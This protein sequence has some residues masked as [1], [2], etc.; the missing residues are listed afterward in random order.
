MERRPTRLVGVIETPQMRDA[1]GCQDEDLLDEVV[2]MLPRLPVGLI[3]IDQ[4]VTKVRDDRNVDVV[5]FMRRV[6]QDVGRSGHVTVPQVVT[7]NVVVVH[8]HDRNVA[9]PLAMMVEQ[10][11]DGASEPFRRREV[12]RRAENLHHAA[13]L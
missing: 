10:E 7:G 12:R 4:D 1:M 11:L 2:A 13:I 9:V 6:G 8:E 5:R 3:E